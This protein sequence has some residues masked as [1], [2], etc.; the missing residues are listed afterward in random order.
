MRTAKGITPRID[1]EPAR[2]P[3]VRLL[4]NTAINSVLTLHF[5]QAFNATGVQDAAGR[6]EVRV[7]R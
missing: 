2:V 4:K 1:V 7:R 3:N 6:A 5:W